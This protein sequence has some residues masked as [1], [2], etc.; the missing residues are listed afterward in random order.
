MAKTQPTVAPSASNP[1]PSGVSV[2]SQWNIGSLIGSGINT[3]KNTIGD[4]A[5]GIKN[6]VSSGLHSAENAIFGN[7]AERA[8]AQQRVHD[9]TGPQ[10][11]V[12]TPARTE[13][14][15]FEGGQ[16]VGPWKYNQD[17]S[18][19]ADANLHEND[20]GVDEYG[21]K[22][23]VNDLIHFRGGNWLRHDFG[24]EP[25]EGQNDW[26]PL[27]VKHPAVTRTS[28]PVGANTNYQLGKQGVVGASGTYLGNQGTPTA[29][30]AANVGRASGALTNGGWTYGAGSSG[31]AGGAT[32]SSF[33]GITGDEGR[34][35]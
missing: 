14:G 27:T 13:T 28:Y 17:N 33:Q 31:N 19:G 20:N 30:T 29:V 11:T 26:M 12:I 7:P 6:T 22:Y 8:T 3:V 2:G 5:S 9:V 21:H 32:A 34:Q 23:N 18:G 35:D 24:A 4:V 1:T 25:G 10:T 15:H 16:P